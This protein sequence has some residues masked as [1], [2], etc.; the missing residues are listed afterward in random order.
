MNW[1]DFLIGKRTPQKISRYFKILAAMQLATFLYHF[2]MTYLTIHGWAWRLPIKLSIFDS[3][4]SLN[5]QYQFP[6]TV[7]IY[8]ISS[9]IIFHFPSF[10]AWLNT[11][12]LSYFIVDTLKWAIT[13]FAL[14]QLSKAMS[15]KTDFIGFSTEGVKYLRYAGFPIMFIPILDII[16]NKIFMRYVA[17][18][19]NY[20][21]FSKFPSAFILDEPFT[22][23][24]YI[25]A[26]LILF[27]LAEIFRYGMK[28][29]EETDL[30]V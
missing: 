10:E 24:Y 5:K 25:Y 14:W 18:Q 19:S 16:S 13:I 4:G 8:P 9:D 15:F 26:G 12:T 27:G 28:L 23:W 11:Y 21:G 1:F 22:S 7:D 17:T 30:T 2:N 3:N 20:I 6:D 29:K